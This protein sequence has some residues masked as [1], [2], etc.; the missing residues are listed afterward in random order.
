VR[1]LPHPANLDWLIAEV[2][3][4]EMAQTSP[5]AYG[6][7]HRVNHAARLEHGWT[8]TCGDEGL[9]VMHTARPVA[10]MTAADLEALLVDGLER[11]EALATLWRDLAQTG[12]ENTVT[13]VAAVSGAAPFSGFI[14][15]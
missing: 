13:A 7:L 10:T 1:V 11:A 2:D 5:S 6:A 9:L 4:V 12:D 8:A 15:G 3:V 14:R